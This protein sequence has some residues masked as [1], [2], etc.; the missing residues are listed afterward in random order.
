MKKSLIIGV[1]V[2]LLLVLT[3]GII[4][5]VLNKEKIPITTLDFMNIMQEKGYLIQD[6]KSQYYDNEKIEEAYIAYSSDYSH[7]I[8]FYVLT[9]EEAA[10]KM[11]ESNRYVFENSKGNISSETS[12]TLKNYS[13]YTLSSNGK[14]KVISRIENTLL[15]LNVDSTYENTI[16]DI[17]KQIGY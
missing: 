14:Y 2:I 16:K 17:L 4:F 6:A 5:L 15:Y 1:S 10:I 11:Y 3:F 12:V 7:Q 9:D 13:K 8:E